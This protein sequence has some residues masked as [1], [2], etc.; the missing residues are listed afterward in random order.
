MIE[1]D[2]DAFEKIRRLQPDIV[3]NIAEGQYGVSREAQ[4]PAMLE[5]LNIPYSGSDPLTLAVCLDKSR[6]KEILSYYKIPTPRFSVLSSLSDLSSL[7]AEYPCMVKPLCE[8]SSKG[9]FDAS[10]VRTPKELSAQ[11]ENIF[12]SY[13]EPVIVEEFLPGREFTVA[14]LGNDDEVQ[15]MPVVEIRFDSLPKGVNPIYSFEAKWIWDQSSDPLDIFECPARVTPSL[16]KSIENIC[17]QTYKV[18]RCRDWSRIDL[19]LDNHGNP[20]IIE[21]NPLPGILPKP[22]DNS[23]YPKAARAAG[24]S[25]DE[26]LNRVLDAA[27]KRYGL[28]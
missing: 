26:M 17:R 20:N 3:F 8:G 25:Y 23:C 6:A 27:C 9:I 5:L 14:M 21:I 1:A 7:L 24:I 15:V 2:E 13:N 12:V 28:L 22:E 11:V 10:L 16:Q 18:L 19:R 4:I